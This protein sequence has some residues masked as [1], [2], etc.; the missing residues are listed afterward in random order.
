MKPLHCFA[1]WV[2]NR[3]AGP[4][5]GACHP[6]G[7]ARPRQRTPTRLLLG[8]A[9][10]AL[11]GAAQAGTVSVLTY[12]NDAARTGQNTNETVLTLANVNSNR[13]GK[14]FT[15][16]VDGY[17]L[18]QPL[19]LANVAIPGQGT[20]DVL[21][22]ATEH[23]SVYAFDAHSNEGSNAAPLWQVSFINP[24]AGITTVPYSDYWCGGPT[25]ELGITS[26]PVVDPA[27]GTLYVEASTKETAGGGANYVHRLHALDVTTGAEKF[28]GPVS[29]QATVTGWGDGFEGD[30]QLNFD[31]MQHLQRPGLLL[32]NG[33]VH[34]AFASHCDINPYHGWLL[35][36]DA[37]TLAQ[38]G[39]FNTTPNGSQGG[40]WQSGGGPAADAAGNVYVETGNGTF[41]PANGNYGDSFLRL[42]TTNGL[43][44]LDYFTPFNQQALSDSDVD[45]GSGGP[46]VLP[47][48]AG[49]SLHP[50]LLVGAG[51]EGTIYLLDRDNLG[52]FNPLTDQVV[53]ELFGAIG[54]CFC[55]P[56]YFNHTL[57]Y[58]GVDDVLKAFQLAYGVLTPTPASQSLTV[59]GYP[60]ATPSV[61]AN[62]TSDAIVWAIEADAYAN[63]GP[64]IL[65]AYSATNLAQ[66][67]YNSSQAGIRDNP[68]AAVEPCVPTV[69]NGKVYV[70]AQFAVS[71]FGNGTFVATP[72]VAPANGTFGGAVT[73]T[74]ADA[75]P[76]ASIYY[77]LDGT[78]PT[79]GSL[80][81]RG[82]FAV[83]SSAT[84]NAKAFQA[85]AVASPVTTGAFT[86]VAVGNGTGLQGA[87]YANQSATLTDPPTLTR[88]DPTVD[89]DWGAGPPDPS[90]G[91]GP[92]A[93]R[94]TGTVQPQFNETYTFY[95]SAEDGVRLW[96]SGQLLLD[97]WVDQPLTEWSGSLTLV[98]GQNH[99]IKLEHY[100]HTGDAV[101]QLSWSSPST[102]KA[103]IPQSQLYPTYRQPLLFL[104]NTFT[105]GQ[106]QFQSL[107]LLGQTYVLQ[108]STD[109]K[110]WTP[111]STNAAAAAVL[112]LTDP[113]AANHPS[114][115]YRIVQQ[116]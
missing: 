66:E 93:V 86:V 106:P 76:G 97:Q 58:G 114:R 11:V 80:L 35:A 84:L 2:L 10:A 48:A 89:F 28:S 109:L 44:L 62:G 19:V 13:F 53:D 79:T 82:P 100:H 30:G 6:G 54:Q 107:A 17:V 21:F 67:L 92:F 40:V 65:H 105:N 22:V 51:K 111:L 91:A 5:P 33:L 15:C 32:L 70:G 73:I 94:W 26:T 47:D 98:A 87:Y 16:A 85:G 77:T 64:A 39:V 20:H 90:L 49:N 113:Q 14:L 83:T 9:L 115:F 95:V 56:A 71:V 60:G 3:I 27:S 61:S 55:T 38:A 104:A 31:G 99:L 57:Y 12:H 116:P 34:L 96:V 43:T 101:A 36:Y 37:Q 18:A 63:N 81:Y 108:A 29:L 24:A 69:A 103:I 88:T 74:L 1:A 112:N 59:F 42:A 25:A 41:D 23:D 45:L 110:H 4:S 7:D 72:T 102:P 68:G 50:H 46:V 52:Q 75:T 8:A 78:V